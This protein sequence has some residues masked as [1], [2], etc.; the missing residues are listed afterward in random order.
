[1]KGQKTIGQG[2]DRSKAP[3]RSALRTSNVQITYVFYIFNKK[4]RSKKKKKLLRSENELK[5]T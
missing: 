4:I 5:H 1:M 2:R 3:E